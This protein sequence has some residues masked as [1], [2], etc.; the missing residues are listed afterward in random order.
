MWLTHR[1]HAA[2]RSCRDLLRNDAI[3][4]GNWRRGRINHRTTA[5]DIN[6]LVD[7]TLAIGDRLY[8]KGG[9]A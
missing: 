8:A 7:H 1:F 3:A 4:N 5:A 2:A 9:C 6:A